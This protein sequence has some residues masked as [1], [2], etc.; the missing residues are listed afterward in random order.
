M[1][2]LAGLDVD[3]VQHAAQAYTVAT[4]D[5]NRV[6]L[7]LY[8]APGGLG[9][10]KLR[11]DLDTDGRELLLATNAGMY[12]PNVAP[13][14][15]FL[16]HGTA[17]PLD[18]DD[19]TGNFYLKPN[20]VFWVDAEGAHV[21]RSE[22]Y[23]PI[24]EVRLATQSGPLLLEHGDVHPA[25]TPASS[26]LV[27]R[28]GVCAPNTHTVKIAISADG[29][30]LY[31]FATLFRKLGCTDALYLDGTISV[32]STPGNPMATSQRFSGLLAVTRPT[33]RSVD[34]PVEDASSDR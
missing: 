16:G 23:A 21:A 7:D 27:V 25:F 3:I 13:V 4:V 15:L 30:R 31:D 20:G 33:E 28:S 17:H 5:M 2:I 24:G 34:D 22:S 6:A 29:V 9:I 19:G 12:G 11:A 18:L 14:G 1:P 32:L 10:D 8:G 26:N